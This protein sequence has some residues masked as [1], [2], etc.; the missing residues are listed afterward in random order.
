MTRITL[1]LTCCL[2]PLTLLAE[3]TLSLPGS[4]GERHDPL[5]LPEGKKAVVLYFVSPFCN[6]S[7]SFMEDINALTAEFAEDFSHFVV[8]AERGLTLPIVLQHTEQFEVKT[9]ALHDEELELAKKT[10]ATIT[11]EAVV[12][13]SDLATLYQGRI[14]DLYL[15][16]TNRQREATKHDLREVLQ[17]LNEGK[18]P[19]VTKTEAQ[20]CKISGLDP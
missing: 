6:T 2:A 7:N 3:E 12:L 18:A 8:H 10:G 5:I 17:A 15:G 1:F 9:L 14:N 13:G 11:P 20:G 19:S 16:P 4:D